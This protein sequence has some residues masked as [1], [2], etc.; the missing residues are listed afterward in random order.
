[1]KRKKRENLLRNLHRR[2]FFKKNSVMKCLRSKKRMNALLI[3]TLV[4]Q[5]T[6]RVSECGLRLRNFQRHICEDDLYQL[7]LIDRLDPGEIWSSRTIPA[8]SLSLTRSFSLAI[9]LSLV[10]L[11]SLSAYYGLFHE[12][13]LSESSS[14]E[15]RGDRSRRASSV[16]RKLSGMWVEQGDTPFHP[17]F[18]VLL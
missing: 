15:F 18:Y 13:E 1:M 4:D 9:S 3:T 10:T 11:C 6:P 8:S 14:S 12:R 17:W 7:V 5:K 16:A 2:I